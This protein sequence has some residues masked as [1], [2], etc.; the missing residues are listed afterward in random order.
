MQKVHTCYPFHYGITCH[1]TAKNHYKG[2]QLTELSS[3]YNSIILY[4][5]GMGHGVEHGHQ[6]FSRE[7]KKNTKS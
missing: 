2:G 7:Y 1:K 3:L 4:G 6:L 5:T